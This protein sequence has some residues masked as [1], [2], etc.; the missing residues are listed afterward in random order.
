M[1][2]SSKEIMNKGFPLD[3]ASKTCVFPPA[4]CAELYAE[5]KKRVWV[6]IFRHV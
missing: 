1:N 5:Y 4:R 6:S 2:S 3:S